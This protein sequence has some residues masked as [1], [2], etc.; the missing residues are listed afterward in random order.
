METYIH[1]L[2]FLHPAPTSQYQQFMPTKSVT[3][4]H[5]STWIIGYI[6]MHCAS[7]YGRK[8]LSLLYF[9]CDFNVKVS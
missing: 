3:A 6:Q 1:L 2:P 5:F 8:Y 4:L 7:Q 9:H